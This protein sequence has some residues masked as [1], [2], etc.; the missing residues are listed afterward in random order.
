MQEIKDSQLCLT[1]K[2]QA[3]VPKW[4]VSQRA[5]GYFVRFCRKNNLFFYYYLSCYFSIFY[6]L[7]L[8]SYYLS[9]WYYQI[10]AYFYFMSV[11]LQ[12][13]FKKKKKENSLI[14]VFIFINTDVLNIHYIPP[15]SHPPNPMES[16]L[17]I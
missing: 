8:F 3:N 12:N 9:L 4:M 2:I 14:F 15:F 17:L 1:V 13:I 7:F 6:F 11:C 5:I 16:Q 10:N